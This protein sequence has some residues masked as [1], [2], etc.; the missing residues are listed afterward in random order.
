[1]LV[2]TGFPQSTALLLKGHDHA[3][4]AGSPGD[5]VDMRLIFLLPEDGMAREE[6]CQHSAEAQSRTQKQSQTS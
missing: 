6:K 3:C 5:G 1:M 2:Q 4:Y